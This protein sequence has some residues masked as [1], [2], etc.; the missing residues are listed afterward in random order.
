M[1]KIYLLLV[2]L[3]VT[4]CGPSRQEST[5]SREGSPAGS[6]LQITAAG[7][8][9]PAPIYQKWFADFHN[10][11]PNVQINYQPIGSGAGIQQLL[12]GTVDFG[13]S[14]MPLTDEELSK[15]NV[16]PLLFPTVL[17]G[18]VPTYNPPGTPSELK[19]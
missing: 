13:A 16:R 1:N 5:A 12:K 10:E 3:L 19:F 18:V 4:G 8:T 17:G 14:D 11:H 9:F 6:P 7:A 2:A 15:F